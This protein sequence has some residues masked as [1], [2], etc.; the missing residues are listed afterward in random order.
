M[1]VQVGELERVL[2]SSLNR[3]MP[4]VVGLIAN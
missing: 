3:A 4:A 2:L 1:E